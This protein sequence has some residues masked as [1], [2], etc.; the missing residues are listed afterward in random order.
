MS[1]GLLLGVIGAIEGISGLLVAAVAQTGALSTL[2]EGDGILM[3]ILGVA[4]SLI[5]LIGAAGLM[6]YAFPLWVYSFFLGG[7]GFSLLQTVIV[8]VHFK[9]TSP[10]PLN[11]EE[12]LFWLLTIS[13][14]ARA[15]SYVYMWLYIDSNGPPTPNVDP[16]PTPEV[17]SEKKDMDAGLISMEGLKPV[18]PD[19]IQQLLANNQI[20]LPEHQIDVTEIKMED[21]VLADN[22]QTHG[23]KQVIIM[24]EEIKQETVP[25]QALE[26]EK[27]PLI[28]E[29]PVQQPEYPSMP[30]IQS[31]L[32]GSESEAQELIP[33]SAE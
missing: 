16:E 9:A 31:P 1:F 13:E 33:I 28:E 30:E 3:A 12:I 20:A 25:T 19:E 29:T 2:T 21:L 7:A 23:E 14:I 32:S 27:V 6:G 26:T 24:P 11:Y 22:V 8:Q 4:R 18:S 10:D 5:T 17:D 15:A